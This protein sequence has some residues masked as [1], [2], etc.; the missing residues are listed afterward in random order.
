MGPYNEKLALRLSDL[1]CCS[2]QGY[3]DGSCDSSERGRCDSE[4]SSALEK[5]RESP[6]TILSHRSS[7]KLQQNERKLKLI[8]SIQHTSSIYT[9]CSIYKFIAFHSASASQQPHQG[10]SQSLHAQELGQKIRVYA[11]TSTLYYEGVNLHAADWGHEKL[12][13]MTNTSRKCKGMILS[14]QSSVFNKNT[15]IF[16]QRSLHNAVFN[17]GLFNT[18]HIYNAYK[19]I[20]SMHMDT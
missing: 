15:S 7:N 4:H 10:R 2:D 16:S 6:R 17:T 12:S 19:N 13:W 11:F 9:Q 8:N 20:Y 5:G 14:L 18:Q 3:G 1:R